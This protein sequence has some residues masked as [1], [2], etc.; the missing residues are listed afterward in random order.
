M[1]TARAKES[2]SEM[3]K[4][5]IIFHK[6]NPIQKT[7]PATIAR[8]IHRRSSIVKLFDQKW[9]VHYRLILP[10]R[11]SQKYTQQTIDEI[12]CLSRRTSECQ[13]FHEDYVFLYANE[14]GVWVTYS[15]MTCKMISEIRKAVA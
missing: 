14:D 4:I 11:R 2:P 13:K 6:K 10:M 1:A 5:T 8:I 7:G 9:K 12:S 3:D 15:I